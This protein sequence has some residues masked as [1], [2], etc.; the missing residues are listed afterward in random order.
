MA[1]GQELI[2][3]AIA[4]ASQRALDRIEEVRARREREQQQRAELA[5]ARNAGLARRHAARLRRQREAA[6]KQPAPESLSQYSPYAR[7]AASTKE[8]PRGAH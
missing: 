1:T 3:A 7:E 6:D 5:A 2:E 8:A 4:A